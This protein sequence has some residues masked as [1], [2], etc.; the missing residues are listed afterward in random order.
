[1]S[2]FCLVQQWKS[3]LTRI[4]AYGFGSSIRYI[5]GFILTACYSRLFSQHLFGLYSLYYTISMMVIMVAEVQL[6]SAIL[7]EYH[8]SPAEKR[9]LLLNT[10]WHFYFL[11]QCFAVIVFICLAL[12]QL[13]VALLLLPIVLCMAPYQIFDT[14]D[15]VARLNFRHRLYLLMNLAEG[16]LIVLFA[17]ILIY[18]LKLGVVAA[19]FAFFAPRVLLVSTFFILRY[20]YRFSWLP[21][22]YQ[23]LRK[24]IVYSAPILLSVMSGW[25]F[26]YIARFFIAAKYGLASLAVYAIIFQVAYTLNFI[27][28]VIRTMWTPLVMHKISHELSCHVSSFVSRSM[29]LYAYGGLI[30]LFVLI[31][32][33]KYILMLIAPSPYWYAAG[34]LKYAFLMVY[35]QGFNLY[36]SVGNL[37]ARKTG[38]NAV[39]ALIGGGLFSAA[40]F[41]LP[42]QHTLLWPLIAIDISM[43]INVLIIWFFSQKHHKIQYAYRYL[44]PVVLCVPTLMVVM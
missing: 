14:I 40:L 8:E 28:Q 31:A 12:Y 44:L 23:L 38:Y 33:S 35:L 36:V 24:L 19:L 17:F 21:M 30:I 1:M 4:M 6:N 34:L 32:I 43:L 22:D 3:R 13:Q 39:G 16:V 9:S 10:I 18:V 42:K 25:L 7:R 20:P 11:I 5:V 15:T 26:S 27:L 41:F 37:W 2:S 29:L